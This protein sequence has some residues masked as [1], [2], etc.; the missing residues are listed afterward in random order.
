MPTAASQQRAA[1]PRPKMQ[2]RPFWTRFG[3]IH[4][5]PRARAAR[6]A[7]ERPRRRQR[8]PRGRAKEDGE[9]GAADAYGAEAGAAELVAREGPPV[10]PDG[11][12]EVGV[13]RRALSLIY[14]HRAE[15]R[16]R[17]VRVA[18]HLDAE[19]GDGGV[20][21]RRDL[22][23]AAVVGERERVRRELRLDAHDARPHDRVGYVFVRAEPPLALVVP[24]FGVAAQQ[25]D[26]HG[27]EGPRRLALARHAD[28]AP[29]AG[30]RRLLGEA[31]DGVAVH[32]LGVVRVRRRV[33]PEVRE[34]PPPRRAV[35]R[36]HGVAAPYQLRHG[37]RV[38]DVAH[39]QL[40]GRRQVLQPLRDLGP[41]ARVVADR[42]RLV[43]HEAPH[44]GA[45]RDELFDGAAAEAAR[46]ARDG[47]LR[48]VAAWRVRKV[49]SIVWWL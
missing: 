41:R 28:D 15:R 3:T 13:R 43:A 7:H 37:A 11:R 21:D 6:D 46:R 29:A 16:A 34:P 40:H 10:R 4:P 31:V 48:A 14:R 8:A 9:R 39:E 12:Q 30:L 33:L 42:R 19:V 35:E 36:E 26:E 25:V 45:P 23:V 38:D 2:S 27:E 32:V 1:R 24:G 17:G 44:G 49:R 18:Q 5:A 47:Y 22:E 20:R